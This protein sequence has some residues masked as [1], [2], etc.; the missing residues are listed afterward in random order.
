MCAG[1]GAKLI[2]LPENF[3]FMGRHYADG[4]EIAEPL[5]GPIIKKYKQLALDNRVW[6]S[7]G[8]FPEYCEINPEKRYSKLD[9]LLKLCENRYSYCHK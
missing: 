6:I 2:C 9:K 5:S 4:I 7:L 8:G 3:H 1:R